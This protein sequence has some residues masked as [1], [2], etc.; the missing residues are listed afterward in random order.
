MQ[1][2]ELNRPRRTD[3]GLGDW[4]KVAGTA[5]KQ[6]VAGPEQNTSA[7]SAGILDPKQKLAAVMR[8]PAM[9]K[10]ATEY[11]KEWVATQPK[12][13]PEAVAT[14]PVA[15]PSAN[16]ST[17]FNA[18][19][20]M[21]LPGMG[22]NVKPGTAPATT[23]NFAGPAGARAMDAMAKQLGGTPA[24]TQPTVPGTAT[25][26]A[27]NAVPPTDPAAAEYRKKFLAFANEKIAMR[28]PSTYQMIGLTAVEKLPEP[29]SL[30]KELDAAKAA[31][32]A[33]QGKPA[34]TEAAV[35]NYILTAMA[36]AQLVASANAVAKRPAPAY[37]DGEPADP[38]D[39]ATTAQGTPVTAQV[40][41]D[42]ITGLITKAGL[43]DPKLKV[44]GSNLQNL[45]GNR[46]VS[47]TGDSGVDQLLRSMG[48]TVS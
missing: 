18:S 44:M 16:K 40:T 46:A 17:G 12:S 24:T 13:V 21:K 7:A 33:A 37:N 19:N 25:T 36:G 2:H 32:V 9:V 5:L 30:K 39:P 11:A 41:P 42:Q 26:A 22:K 23:S 38:A 1:I 35:K 8:E 15:N 31:V 3:E 27:Q 6:A 20:V 28:D 45:S 43:D 48:Y 47:S 34:E 14:A 4:A 29:Y 10:L